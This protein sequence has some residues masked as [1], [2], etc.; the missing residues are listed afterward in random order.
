MAVGWAGVKQAAARLAAPVID[1]ALPP[2]CAGCG[3]IVESIDTF[4]PGCWQDI[5]FLHGALCTCCGEPLGSFLPEGSLCAPCIGSPPVFHRA[6]AA[7]AYGPVARLVA[8]RLKYGRRTSHARLMARHMAR[9]LPQDARDAI[10]VPVP[11]HRLRLWS[12]GFNQAVAL[13]RALAA[14]CDAILIPDALVRKVNTPPLHELGRTAR[15]RIVKGAFAINPQA[16]PLLRDRIVILVDDIWTTGATVSACARLLV[17]A[18]A[19]R[20]EILCW[21]RVTQEH[22][23]HNHD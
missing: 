21:T 23:G 7:T 18:G 13:G 15:A 3:V 22:A 8:H 17:A 6:R 5:D 19:K 10:V 11:L 16:L 14:S 2:R 12:R 4:C 20:V 1:Y 9:L